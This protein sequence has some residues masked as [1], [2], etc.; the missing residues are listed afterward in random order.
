MAKSNF[1]QL[2]DAAVFPASIGSGYFKKS[3]EKLAKEWLP[4]NSEYVRKKHKLGDK[5]IKNYRCEWFYQAVVLWNGDIIYCCYDVNGIFRFGNVFES[6][7]KKCWYNIKHK[8]L[9]KAVSNKKP[10]LCMT[11]DCIH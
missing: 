3:K 9:V 8:A 6:G 2:W 10:D 7:F 5:E 1:H 11:D 4:T